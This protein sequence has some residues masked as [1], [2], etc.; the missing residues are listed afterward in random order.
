MLLVTMVVQMVEMVVM[1]AMIGV[2][3]CVGDHDGH[4]VGCYVVG[5]RGCVYVCGGC[6]MMAMVM[7]A[8]AG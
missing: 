7:V 4:R 2:G 1:L 3:A 6:S 5:V 8:M